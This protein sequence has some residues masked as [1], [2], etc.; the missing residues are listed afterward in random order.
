MRARWCRACKTLPSRS[1]LATALQA[2]SLNASCAPPRLHSTHRPPPCAHTD[3]QADG[4]DRPGVHRVVCVPLPPLPGQPRGAG[5]V[6]CFPGQGREGGRGVSAGAA[7]LGACAA[8]TRCAQA[9][10][11]GRAWL[12]APPSHPAHLTAAAASP[13]PL[14]CHQGRR[15]HQKQDH[16]GRVLRGQPPTPHGRAWRSR[17]LAPQLTAVGAFTHARSRTGGCRAVDDQPFVACT[18]AMC[19]PRVDATA[20]LPTAPCCNT[21]GMRRRQAQ[22]A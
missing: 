21:H 2:P 18:Y 9:R 7:R 15:H 3:P 8:S 22:H 14:P 20:R 1:A 19:P 10:A 17:V 13:A 5:K 4:A 12:A 6:S 11:R 16:G